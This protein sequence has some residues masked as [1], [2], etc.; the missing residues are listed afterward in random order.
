MLISVYKLE[1]DYRRLIKYV[2]TNNKSNLNLLDGL[3]YIARRPRVRRELSY[4]V[5]HILTI[6]AGATF[7]Y[8]SPEKATPLYQQICHLY[9]RWRTNKY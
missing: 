4:Y 8:E 2:E 1:G 9:D 3:T 7:R 6:K 5:L